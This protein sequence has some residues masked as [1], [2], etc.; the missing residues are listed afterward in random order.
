MRNSEVVKSSYCEAIDERD[1]SQSDRWITY[2]RNISK[3]TLP[4]V[5]QT[6]KLLWIS[7]GTYI[8]FCSRFASISQSPGLAC[9][10]FACSLTYVDIA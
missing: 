2:E 3:T 8:S 9:P 7:I 10:P 6:L 5:L 1:V 4:T